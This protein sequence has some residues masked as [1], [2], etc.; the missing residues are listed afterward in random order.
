MI[1]LDKSRIVCCLHQYQGESR[2]GE[3]ELW[4]CLMLAYVLM[5]WLAATASSMDH[6]LWGWGSSIHCPLDTEVQYVLAVFIG[7]IWD[8]ILMNTVW[9]SDQFLPICLSFDLS[10]DILK[11]YIGAMILIYSSIC[12]NATSC[13][14]RIN[15]LNKKQVI[16][17][18]FIN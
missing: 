3:D 13:W 4:I 7:P 2:R 16:S 17:R 12:V 11:Q 10:L 15:L 5:W 14:W 18:I 1:F 6:M 8:C 9:P